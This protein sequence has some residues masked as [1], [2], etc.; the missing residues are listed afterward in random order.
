M[1][2]HAYNSSVWQVEAEESKDQIS[3]DNVMKLHLKKIFN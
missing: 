3:L 1:V 2:V